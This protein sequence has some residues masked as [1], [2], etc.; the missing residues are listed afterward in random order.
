V[1]ITGATTGNVYGMITASS[2]SAP[3]TTVT[4]S[5]IGSLKN[6]TLTGYVASLTPT[7]PS[8]NSIHSI[9]NVKDFGAVGDGV[10]DDTTA[11]A[12]AFTA[13][14]ALDNKVTVYIPGTPMI[15]DTVTVSVVSNLIP[16]I[17]VEKEIIYNGANTKTALKIGDITTTFQTANLNLSIKNANQSDWSNDS[18]IGIELINATACSHINIKKAANFTNGVRFSGNGH[19]VAYNTTIFGDLSNNKYGV[20]LMPS[21]SGWVNENLYIG[22]RYT[23]FDGINSTVAR[24]GA[25]VGRAGASQAN[26]NVFIKPSFEMNKADVGAGLTFGVTFFNAVQNHVLYCRSE[27]T[28]I[29]SV[30]DATSTENEV[31]IG[32]S[33]ASSHGVTYDAD[34]FAGNIIRYSRNSEENNSKVIYDIGDLKSRAGLFAST[35]GAIS[36]LVSVD[37]TTGALSNAAPV[38]TIGTEDITLTNGGRALGAIIDVSEQKQFVLSCGYTGNGGRLFVQCYDASDVLLTGTTPSYAIGTSDAVLTAS[39]QGYIS[40]SDSTVNRSVRFTDAVKRAF[41][42]VVKGTVNPQFNSFRIL[43]VDDADYIAKP[44][45]LTK[46]PTFSMTPYHIYGDQAPVSNTWKQ[47]DRIYNTNVSVDGNNMVLDHW[48]CIAAGTPGT[49]VAQYLSTVSPA[50]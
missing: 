50:T 4:I 47:G 15:T 25:R 6:E 45:V 26:N 31:I 7:N 8:Y 32:F 13:A 24:Y 9:V 23:V 21:N 48:V 44:A 39:G 17:I 37:T 30:F 33:D 18:C 49:W 46:S 22:G 40:G 36:G 38:M 16:D 5:A 10:A 27:G 29:V 3:N 14:V 28:E 43:A 20:D 42:G 41:I 2:Y 35:L 12:A 11:I 34:T 1:W 19:G